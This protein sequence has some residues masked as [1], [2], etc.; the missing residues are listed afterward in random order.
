MNAARVNEITVPKMI[1][2]YTGCENVTLRTVWFTLKPQIYS[3][4]NVY[5]VFFIQTM[6]FCTCLLCALAK[7]S[8]VFFFFFV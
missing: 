1:S 7:T 4:A 8:H 2:S 5:A 3:P 6:T